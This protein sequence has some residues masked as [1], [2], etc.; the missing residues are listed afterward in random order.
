MF[1]TDE[2]SVRVFFF[3]LLLQPGKVNESTIIDPSLGAASGENPIDFVSIYCTAQYSF[4]AKAAAVLCC[5]APP[6]LDQM[7]VLV[8]NSISIF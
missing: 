3:P 8:G 1:A 5:A 4:Q 6:R 2:T 7:I